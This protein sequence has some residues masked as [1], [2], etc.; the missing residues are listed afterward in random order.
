MLQGELHL[1]EETLNL[2]SK[3]Q[4]SK[5]IDGLVKIR[6]SYNDYQPVEDRALERNKALRKYSNQV[7]REHNARE[8]TCKV[9]R[10]SKIYD[11]ETA[12]CHC[13]LE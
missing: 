8:L 5:I 10:G 1:S 7:T 2:L 4:A 11:L 9:C 6:R 12:N 13:W 3:E